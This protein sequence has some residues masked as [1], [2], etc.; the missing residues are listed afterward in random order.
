VAT[1]TSRLDWF[2]DGAQPNGLVFFDLGLYRIFNLRLSFAEF[3]CRLYLGELDY[4]WASAVKQTIWSS[5][6]APFF[7][8]RADL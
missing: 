8:P 5:S 3:V 1:T 7:R 2:I 6:D 4:D